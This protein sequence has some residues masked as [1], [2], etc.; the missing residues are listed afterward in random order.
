MIILCQNVAELNHNR[1]ANGHPFPIFMQV[2]NVVDKWDD[3]H[4]FDDF[5]D[6]WYAV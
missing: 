3:L 5:K 2:K 6:Y 1:L 4:V